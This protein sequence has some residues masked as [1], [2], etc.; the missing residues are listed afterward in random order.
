MS[1]RHEPLLWLQCLALGAIPLELLLIRLLLAGADPGPVPAVERILLWGVGAVAPAIALWKRPADWGSML[2]VR[3]PTSGRS[4][5]QQALSCGQ[6]NRIS[7]AGVLVAGI[8]LLPLIWW[9]DDSAVLVGE[10]SPVSAQSRLVTLLLSTP[11][12]AVILWQ[13]QQLTQA[14]FWLI[15]NEAKSA[16]EEGS[17]AE[18]QLHEERT[19]LGLQLLELA[20]L[21]W[22]KRPASAPTR[23]PEEVV[24]S[25]QDGEDSMHPEPV[26][27]ITEIEPEPAECDS[28]DTALPLEATEIETVFGD[29][30]EGDAS[31]AEN[32]VRPAEEPP[33]KNVLQNDSVAAAVAVEPDQTG[34]EDEGSSLDSE[35]TEIDTAASREAES[36]GEQS[37]PGGSAESEPERTSETPPGVA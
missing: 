9:I 29:T 5:E 28:E 37:E 24:P 36:H 19:S 10:F 11:V 16:N 4:A 34:E 21:N 31:E 26:A 30:S 33:G 32:E 2:V 3:R 12:L 27:E 23:T 35:I 7:E 1:P 17:F 8:L 15:T 18:P 14:G 25:D 6:N 20:Q 22:P 13:A